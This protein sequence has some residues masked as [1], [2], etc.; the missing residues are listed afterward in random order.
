MFCTQW[1]NILKKGRAHW[2]NKKE[3]KAERK[4]EK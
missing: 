1:Q 3:K 4:E 2:T